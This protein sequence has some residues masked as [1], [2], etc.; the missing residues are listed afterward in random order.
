VSD[1]ALFDCASCGACCCNS[2]PNRAARFVDYVEVKRR[3]PLFREPA[4]LTQLTVK[5]REGELHL[6][7]VG[8][9]QRCTALEGRVGE[10]VSC[11]IYQLRPKPCRDLAP[12]SEECRD[13]RR[14]KR[15]RVGRP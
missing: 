1:S 6:R 12:G 14:E 3:D 8:R 15:L 9:S 2:A 13:R 11:A 7:L 4:L 10:S 5:N